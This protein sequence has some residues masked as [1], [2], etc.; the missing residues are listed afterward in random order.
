MYIRTHR[1]T[2]GYLRPALLGR[3][4]RKVDL[5]ITVVINEAGMSNASNQHFICLTSHA[6]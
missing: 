1:Q 2:D 3:L 4:C 6:G 5:I